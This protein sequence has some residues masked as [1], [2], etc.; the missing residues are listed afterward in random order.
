MAQYYEETEHSGDAQMYRVPDE[1]TQTPGHPLLRYQAWYIRVCMASVH[2]EGDYGAYLRHQIQ[3]ETESYHPIGRRWAHALLMSIKGVAHGIKMLKIRDWR[4][5]S[6]MKLKE[7]AVIIEDARQK[8]VS[9][10]CCVTPKRTSIG[11]Q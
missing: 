7:H 3:E 9:S 6:C 1:F 5:I 10:T 11:G 2:L 4:A 8:G